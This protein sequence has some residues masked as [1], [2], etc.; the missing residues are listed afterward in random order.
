MYI[1]SFFDGVERTVRRL[2]EDQ[3][4]AIDRAAVLVSACLRQHGVVHVYDANGWLR[5]EA[6]TRAGALYAL[7]PLHFEC[8]VQNPVAQRAGETLDYTG[9][10]LNEVAAALDY[11]NVRAKDVVILHCFDGVAPQAIELARQ[12]VDRGV[13]TVGLASEA[14]MRAQGPAHTSG[15]KLAKV[16]DIFIDTCAPKG[17]ALVPAKDNEPMCPA[18]GFMA[19]ITLWAIQAAAMTFLQNDGTQPTVRRHTDLASSQIRVEKQQR[20]LERGI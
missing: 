14:H 3:R 10:L 17:D 13:V 5:H 19:A 4:D 9:A 20:Y 7:T 15:H 6:T 1:E 11:S 16:C 18:S 12:C 2:A 8:T